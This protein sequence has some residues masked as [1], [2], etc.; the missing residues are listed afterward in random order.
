MA[1]SFISNTSAIPA[2]ISS[3]ISVFA[4]IDEVDL[5][6]SIRVPLLL[7]IIL[8]MPLL[9]LLHVPVVVAAAAAAIDD[10]KGVDGML[11]TIL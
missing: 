1:S 10:E 4:V 8:L 11:E 6:G 2:S 7:L 9:L 5:D 3:D